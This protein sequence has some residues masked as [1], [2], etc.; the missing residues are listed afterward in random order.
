[1][2]YTEDTYVSPRAYCARFYAEI[3]GDARILRQRTASIG[4]SELNFITTST[5]LTRVTCDLQSF[6]TNSTLA[7]RRAE[8][9]QMILQDFSNDEN[10]AEISKRR[11]CDG[12]RASV[13]PRCHSPC[14]AVIHL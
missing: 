13:N 12:Q 6:L 11:M 3:D 5:C 4:T 14:T 1:M 2:W 9:R 10:A 8:K 7:T